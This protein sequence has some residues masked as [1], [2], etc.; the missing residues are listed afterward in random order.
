MLHWVCLHN[1]QQY[2]NLQGF[3]SSKNV[4]N[5]GVPQGSILGLTLFLIFINDLPHVVKA[6][7]H[8]L[9]RINDFV[10]NC[11]SKT[12]VTM[13]LF[14]DDTTFVCVAPME[15]L[16]MSMINAEMSKI[17]TW[18]KINHL[19]LNIDK[20]I[21]FLIHCYIL[22]CS[23]IWLGTFPSIVCSI[24]VIQNNTIRVFCGVGN[25]ESLRSVYR[26]LNIMP[27]AGLRDF[28]I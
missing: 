2:V 26:D 7:G 13:P 24:S 6:S 1:K 3:L 17:C 21:F 16:L 20:S 23:S 18:L 8:A 9:P 12:Q 25:Q 5:W 27:T 14:G 11:P 4:V 15:Q 22:Y 10:D 28:Y 19:D